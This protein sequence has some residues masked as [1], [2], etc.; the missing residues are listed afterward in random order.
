MLGQ[1][2]TGLFSNDLYFVNIFYD[3][4][5]IKVSVNGHI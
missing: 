5:V 4:Y 2:K 3:T 1:I